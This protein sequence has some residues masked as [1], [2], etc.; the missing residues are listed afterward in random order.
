MDL[1]KPPLLLSDDAVKELRYL[2]LEEGDNPN[3]RSAVTSNILNCET[4]EVKSI[5]F[6]TFRLKKARGE[7]IDDIIIP[8]EDISYFGW[9]H[10]GP[11]TSFG[12]VFKEVCKTR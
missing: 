3:V 9:D 8:D 7:V 11:K 5:T 1:L 4:K 2:K 12:M 10:Y 6:H